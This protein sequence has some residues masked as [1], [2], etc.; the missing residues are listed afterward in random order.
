MQLR[1]DLNHISDNLSSPNDMVEQISYMIFG[2][3]ATTTRA[4]GKIEVKLD[5]NTQRV[6]VSIET[7]WF[8]KHEKMK[9]IRD[10]WLA[11][12]ERKALKMAPKG[13]SVLAYYK[14]GGSNDE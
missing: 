5:A 10:Y 4:F 2:A 1:D 12:A 13:W 7:R 8:A 11:K 6:F 14:N 9:K 3:V